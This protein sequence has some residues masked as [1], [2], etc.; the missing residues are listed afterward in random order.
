MENT[1]VLY[2]T[3]TTLYM[4]LSLSMPVIIAATSIG[5]LIA[6][7]QA[8]FQVQEQTL[9][10][11]AKLMVVVLVFYIMGEQMASEISIFTGRMLDTFKDL[12]R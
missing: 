9:S 6:I 12:T 8:V 4:V 3:K 10:F 7:L 2:L 5:L 1:D 11:A